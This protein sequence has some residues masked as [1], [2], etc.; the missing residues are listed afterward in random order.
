MHI[1]WRA[2]SLHAAVVG[3]ANSVLQLV[4]S[5]GVHLSSDENAAITSVLNSLLLVLSVLVIQSTGGSETQK[6]AA[7]VAAGSTQGG[8]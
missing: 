4:S 7:A 2:S 8:G 5:F 3:L 1:N 6:T